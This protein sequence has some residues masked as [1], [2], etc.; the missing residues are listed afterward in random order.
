MKSVL[1]TYLDP[2][3]W[4]VPV[5]SK[6]DDFFDC[7]PLSITHS[8]ILQV[9][10][11]N[12]D[13]LCQNRS[14]STIP[15]QVCLLTEG[16][17]NMAESLQTKFNP[18]LLFCLYSVIENAGNPNEFISSAGKQCKANRYLIFHELPV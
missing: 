14:Y 7:V 16:I 17:G 4:S 3:Y 10:E 18:L 1:K 13:T 12:I 9:M 15:F 2:V 11:T 6:G 5:S 8:N